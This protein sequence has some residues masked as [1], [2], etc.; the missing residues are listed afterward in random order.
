MAMGWS[1]DKDWGVKVEVGGRGVRIK[2]NV[3]L[4]AHYNHLV[5]GRKLKGRGTK[6]WEG[7]EEHQRTNFWEFKF[8]YSSYWTNWKYLDK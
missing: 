2:L 3:Y 8:I 6:I 1:W 7:I 5:C 4:G